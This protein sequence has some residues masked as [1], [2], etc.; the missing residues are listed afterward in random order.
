L[1]FA[2]LIE[3]RNKAEFYYTSNTYIKTPKRDI[4]RDNMAGKFER[5]AEP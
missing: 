5:R 2:L 1:S 3:T 4:Y